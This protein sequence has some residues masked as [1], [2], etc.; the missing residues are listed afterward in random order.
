MV[1]V[2]YGHMPPSSLS[3]VLRETLSVFDESGPPLTTSEVAD[4]LPVGRRSA[5]ERLERLVDHDRLDTKAVGASGRIWW[6]PAVEDDSV[7]RG[8]STTSRFRALFEHVPEMI[9]ILDPEG[10]LTAVNSRLCNALGYAESELVGKGIWEY[11]TS[12]DANGVETMLSAIAAGERRRFEARYQRADG[13]TFPVE[14]H[15]IRLDSAGEDRF[16][17]ISRDISDRKAREG[18]LQ[19]RIR[20]QEA[21]A[22][23]GQRALSGVDPDEL[24]AEAAE[25]VA[26]TL[27][28]DY[29][30]V[31]DLRAEANELLVRQGIGWDEGVVGSATVSAV[32][33]GSQASQTLMTEEAVVV[34]DLE[35]D[36]RFSGPDLLTTHDVR[37]GISTIIG[38]LEEPWG[39]LGAHDTDRMQ[40]SN[41]DTNFVQ[42]VAN[43]LASVIRR[44]ADEQ[45]L[46]EQ[47]ERVD[48][49]NNLNAVIREITTAV[50][51]QPTREEIESTVCERLAATDSYQLAWIGEADTVSETV[52]LRTE[53]GATGYTDEVTISVDR[54]DQLGS[55]PT[56]TALRTGSTQVVNDIAANTDHDPWQET[57]DAYG[58]ESSAAI[59]ISHEG[60]IYGVLNIYADRRN[61]FTQQERAV[62]DQLGEVIGHAIAAAER[63]QT[64][65]STELVALEYRIGDLATAFGADLDMCGTATL[66][67]VVPLG[68]DEFLVYGTATPAAVECLVELVDTLPY[69]QAVNCTDDDPVRFELRLSDPPVLSEIAAH[70]GYID[71]AVIEGSTY[72]MTIHLSPSADV[73][74]IA[75]LVRD[76]YPQAEMLRRQQITKDTESSSQLQRRLTA[77]LTDRQSTALETAYHSGY[78][79]WPRDSCAEDIAET[80]GVTPA[81]VHQHL[82]KAQ[83]QVFDE[84]LSPTS[85]R[86]LS[87]TH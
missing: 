50:I 60:T 82:R 21:V 7:E 43:V 53:A 8:Q 46:A 31:L 37:S 18:K 67:H 35:T 59:P 47:R 87:S 33:S 51:E 44:Q 54:D 83:Q 10:R 13:S 84:L 38:P 70:G 14:V 58:F 85:H 12:I 71:S 26:E 42:S 16:L 32:E 86:R 45:Q 4:E 28:T 22:E 36:P 49:L 63:K 81:T 17:A 15:L 66:E 24:M 56:A 72:R 64:L 73:G 11:D 75:D 65:M 9:D 30:K 79:A 76:T 41:H 69:W 27:D 2:V 34:T 1:G 74:R 77:R 25:V 3:T 52:D 48:A 68:D 23:L 80:L 57:I 6:Q 19:D 29:C 39:I 40:F 62:V 55:G 61:A 20:Q 5:Y 78:F